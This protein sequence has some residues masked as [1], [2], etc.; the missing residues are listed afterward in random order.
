[1]GGGSGGGRTT[2]SAVYP[3][4]SSVREGAGQSEPPPLPVPLFFRFV[5]CCRIFLG[6]TRRRHCCSISFSVRRLFLRPWEGHLS[7][8]NCAASFVL[9]HSSPAVSIFFVVRGSIIYN[10]VDTSPT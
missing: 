9:A 1:G 5:R 2:T 6:S 10:I 7:R 8:A 4:G 3:R